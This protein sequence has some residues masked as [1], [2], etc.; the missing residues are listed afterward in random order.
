VL[1]ITRKRYTQSR[2]CDLKLYG[3]HKEIFPSPEGHGKS[4]LVDGGRCYTMDYGMKG[5]PTG[6]QQGPGYSHLVENLQEQNVQGAASINE[7]SIELD[8]LD[9]VADNGR[10]PP[11]LWNKVWVVTVIEGDGDLGPLKVLEGSR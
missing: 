2:N 9:D 10:L 11:C 5:S 7:D 4:D 3:L 6:A 1:A 8:I